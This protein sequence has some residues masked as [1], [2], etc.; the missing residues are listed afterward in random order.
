MDVTH[1]A[2]QKTALPLLAVGVSKAVY[3]PL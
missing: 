3:T 2:G 1:A